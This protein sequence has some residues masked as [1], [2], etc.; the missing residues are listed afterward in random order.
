M[1]IERNKTFN[2]ITVI[3]ETRA[4]ADELKRAM[5]SFSG[6]SSGGAVVLLHNYLDSVLSGREGN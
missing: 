2:P 6:W 4:E 1:K 3:I 5:A